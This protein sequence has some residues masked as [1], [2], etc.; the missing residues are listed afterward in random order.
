MNPTQ[1]LVVGAGPTG[2]TAAALLSKLGVRV[3][4][5]DKGA[6]RSDKSKALGVQAGNLECLEAALGPELVSK[7]IA[8]GKPAREAWFH[9]DEHEPIRVDFG[10]IPS[11]HAFVLILEQSETERLLEEEL[12]MRLGVE[13][14]TELLSAQDRGDRVVSSLRLPDGRVEEV[15]SDFLMG[16]D[17]AHSIVRKL[18]AF[19]FEGAAYT[20]DFIL[21]DV[22]IRWRWQYESIRTFVNERGVVASFPMKDEGRYRLI[23]IPKG[24]PQAESPGISREEFAALAAR[25]SGGAIAV[26]RDFW[27]TRF[28]VHHR[29]VGAFRKGRV[30]LAG[31]AAHIHS[32]AGGQGMNTGMQDALNLGFKLARVLG[33]APEGLLDEYDR[34]RRP[35]AQAVVRGTD[36]VWRQALLPESGLV[37]F[38]RAK[39]VP[40][41]VGSRW[42]QRKVVTAISEMNFARREIERYPRQ[43]EK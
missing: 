23:L 14:N 19:P 9:V 4:L 30:C 22:G 1:V 10:A 2:L 16:C 36:F 7:M 38:A 25:L 3:R 29:M 8:R 41:V 42:V 6:A 33:G 13:R 32:P 27:L 15:T 34:E 18:L 12:G 40:R 17:G 26:E 24:A 28:R 37:R 21:G 35:V 5:I 43:G 39:L 31:D 11:R 20:G